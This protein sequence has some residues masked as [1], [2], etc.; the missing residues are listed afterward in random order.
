LKYSIKEL[1]A[2]INKTQAECASMVPTSPQTWNAWEQ[3]FSKVK[4]RDAV[5]V[6]KVLGVTL[7]DVKIFAD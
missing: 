1:R 6:A 7:D 4:L 2:R 3:D 5:K